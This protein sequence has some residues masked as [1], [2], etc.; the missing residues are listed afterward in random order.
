MQFTKIHFF[1]IKKLKIKNQLKIVETASLPFF[2]GGS[3]C[4]ARIKM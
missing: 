2:V 4:L 1:S 3:P